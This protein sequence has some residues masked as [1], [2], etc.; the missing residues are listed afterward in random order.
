MVCTSRVSLSAAAA[1]V[2]VWACCVA[3][4][5]ADSPQATL[6]ERTLTTRGGTEITYDFGRIDVPE[7]RSK[8]DSRSISLAFVRVRSPLESQGPP[9]F[10]L[11]GGPGGPSVE[12]VLKYAQ[13]G[14]VGFLKMLGG[15]VIG[16]D[17]RGV[18]ES[19]PNLTSD[20]K[21]GFSPTDPGDRA[22]MLAIMKRAGR[23]EAKRWRD[24]GVDLTGY[25]TAESAADIDAVRRAL[26]YDQI[27]LWGASYGSHLAM[28]TLKQYDDHI[29][30]AVLIVPEGPDH[31]I[32]LPSY[33]ERAVDKLHEM[34]RA[35]AGLAEK[36][37]DFK[38]A[39]RQVLARLDKE[40]VYV[41]INGKNVGVSKF[42]VQRYV[43]NYIGFRRGMQQIPAVVQRMANGDFTAIAQEL[44]N[45][46]Q[47]DGVGTAMQVM[48]D[49]ASG[50]TK[51]RLQQIASEAKECLLADTVNFPFPDVAEAWGAPDLGDD[52]RG[53]LKSD[54]PVLFIAGDMD[55][56]TPV[57][58]AKELMPGL[59]NAHLIVVKN[60]GHDLRWLNLHE[61]IGDFL[62][63]KPVK[64][65]EAEE[66]PLMFEYP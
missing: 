43:A 24:R 64:I 59:P 8:A 32:K 36:I 33:A 19:E 3:V 48:M 61:A 16:I 27:V 18:G 25:T 37:S 55:S 46:R 13:G 30:R 66:P 47:S 52:F 53:P 23:E 15:D 54:V 2:G 51:E 20:T 49:G 17:Q 44:L 60:A 4:S 31:T 14:G 11:A 7:N 57:S 26:G 10:I 34:V 28:A 1:I 9:V 45:D 40:P 58:N 22:N 6:E 5:A 29:A 41:D 42:D 56:R 63:G 38:G 39:L 21:Y 12:M 50:A 35:D 65:T 62:A